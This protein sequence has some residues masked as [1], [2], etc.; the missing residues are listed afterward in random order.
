MIRRIGLLRGAV[1]S[2]Q[3]AFFGGLH[4][5]LCLIDGKV[6]ARKFME[7]R[8]P[9]LPR[10]LQVGVEAFP[11]DVAQVAVFL[12][13]VLRPPEEEREEKNIQTAAN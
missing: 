9:S 12:R 2:L 13:Y 7:R 6:R 5:K 8:A 3:M 10:A 11:N 4:F 1:I